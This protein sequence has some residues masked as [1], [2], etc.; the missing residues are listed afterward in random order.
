M[1]PVIKKDQIKPITNR[2]KLLEI[3]PNAD[4][5]NIFACDLDKTLFAPP[6][7]QKKCTECNVELLNQPYQP[8]H[9]LYSAAVNPTVDYNE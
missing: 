9:R 6:C 4:V 2:E 1:M 5:D 7:G 3:F 8:P